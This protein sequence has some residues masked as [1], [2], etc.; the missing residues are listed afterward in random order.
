MSIKHKILIICGLIL[1][2][3]GLVTFTLYARSTS[4]AAQQERLSTARAFF[5]QIV[6]TRRWIAQHGGVYVAKGPDVEPNPFLYRIPDLKVDITDTEGQTYTLRNPALVTRELSD[7][8]AQEGIFTFHITSLKLVNPNNAPDGFETKALNAF[9][10]GENEVWR[11]EGAGDQRHFRYMAPLY[12]EE[13]CLRCHGFQGYEVGQVRGGISVTIPATNRLGPPLWTLGLGW[14]LGI[15]LTLLALYWALHANIIAPIERLRAAS[16]AIAAGDYEQPVFATSGDE[17]GALARA[18]ETM[19]VQVQQYTRALEDKVHLRT[20]ELEQSNEEVR[21]FAYIVSHDLRAPLVNIKGFAAELR[22][23]LEVIH[24]SLG[25]VLPHLNE[26]QREAVT[27]A[28]QEDVP[29]ALGFIDSSVTRMDGFINAL[30]KLSR[31]GHR[32]LKLERINMGALVQETLDTLSH[33]IEARQVKVTVGPL[34]EVV[35]DRTSMEQIV[36][37]LLTNAVLYLDPDRPGEIEVASARGPSTDSGRGGDE[38]TFHVR[39]NGRGIA[40]DDMPKVFAPFRRVGRQDVPGEGMGLPYVQ[41][42]VRR[43]GGRIWCDSELGVGTTF[44]FTISN[45]LEKGGDDD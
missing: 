13:P 2:V 25:T 19:R 42:L 45:R 38:T 32:E 34:P 3:V 40:A 43:H 10:A 5:Q 7:L 37:N 30:L 17:I 39:D 41:A 44:S 20:A 23:A 31:L 36:G 15:A 33:Q 12:V 8:A 9:E 27:T 4:A 14:V 29:E 6:L 11:Y 22:S 28:L 18:F 1:L 21:R 16:E 26:S 35:A 24:S